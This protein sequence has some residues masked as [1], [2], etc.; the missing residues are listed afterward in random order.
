MCVHMCVCADDKLLADDKTLSNYYLQINGCNENDKDRRGNRWAR[1]RTSGPKELTLATTSRPRKH[2]A[3]VE[4]KR[5]RTKRTNVCGAIKCV[6]CLDI[7]FTCCCSNFNHHRLVAGRTKSERRRW[8]VQKNQ[9]QR[10]TDSKVFMLWSCLSSSSSLSSL[11]WA[12]R[13]SCW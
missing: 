2:L 8:K 3:E 13:I 1:N 5:T 4:T 9:S 12:Q 11:W 6:W 10:C 7:T